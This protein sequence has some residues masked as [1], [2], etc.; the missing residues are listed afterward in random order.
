MSLVSSEQSLISLMIGFFLAGFIGSWHCAIMCGPMSCFLTSK[1]QL[2]SYQ[3]GRLISYVLAGAFSG[4]VSQFLL[5]SYSWLKYISV[6]TITI[7]LVINFFGSE[8]KFHLSSTFG[9][10]FIRYREN[11][12]LL[13][14]LTVLLPC[15]WLYTFIL[16]A[17]AARSALGGALVMFSFYL[18]TVPALSAGQILMK[19]L[20][21]KNNL[22]KQKIASIVLLCSSLF[23]LWSFLL[24]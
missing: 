18:S 9:K 24:H 12:L 10:Y 15:G 1:K 22:N 2:L 4:W 21:E 13:G 5:N 14:F 3:V 8:K 11:T 20:I 16:S 6:I 17:M 23:S 7:L 19:K